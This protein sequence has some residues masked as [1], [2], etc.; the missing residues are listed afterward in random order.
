MVSPY[1]GSR[2]ASRCEEIAT[3]S[4]QISFRFRYRYEVGGQGKC[5]VTCLNALTKETMTRHLT[6]TL[7]VFNIYHILYGD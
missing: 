1:R 3:E 7:N 6:S 4:L 2:E 5:E